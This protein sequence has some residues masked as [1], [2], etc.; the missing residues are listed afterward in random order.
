LAWTLAL[1]KEAHPVSALLFD[2]TET[3]FTVRPK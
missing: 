1:E 2:W 3:G